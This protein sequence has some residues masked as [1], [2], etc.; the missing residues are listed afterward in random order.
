M[1]HEEGERKRDKPA[2]KQTEND[3]QNGN[4]KPYS[5]DNYLYCKWIILLNQKTCSGRITRKQDLTMFC[6][7]ETQFRFKDTNVGQMK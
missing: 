7:Q 4:S 6:V 2:T 3:S 1:K 5:V